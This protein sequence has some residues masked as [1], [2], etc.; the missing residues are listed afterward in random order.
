MNIYNVFEP[1][2]DNS[3]NIIDIDINKKIDKFDKNDECFICMENLLCKVIVELNNINNYI[4][5]CKCNANV[6][7]DCFEKWINVKSVCPICRKKMK[8]IV[9]NCYINYNN[10]INNHNDNN[11][12]LR[13]IQL[14]YNNRL[15][16]IK[17]VRIKIFFIGIVLLI[18]FIYKDTMYNIENP[19]IKQNK[20]NIT[21]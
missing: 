21:N 16:L 2:G 9:S 6:H 14:N 4:K 12:Y 18:Y 10:N 1:Y 5:D 19:N 15:F 13:F 8:K 11:N 17:M 20:Y 7:L 3:N